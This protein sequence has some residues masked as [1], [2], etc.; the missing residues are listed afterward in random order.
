MLDRDNTI[1]YILL[2]NV[3]VYRDAKQ[4]SY[5][6]GMLVSAGMVATAAHILTAL[7]IPIKDKQLYDEV[8]R[9]IA[10]VEEVI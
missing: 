4:R 7:E 2:E 10:S 5:L 3:K 6:D 9:I 1:K 8:I